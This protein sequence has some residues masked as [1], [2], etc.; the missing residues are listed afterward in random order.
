MSVLFRNTSKFNFSSKSI[1]EN[2]IKSNLKVTKLSIE[3]VSGGCGQAFKV[4]VA[5]SDFK[6][7]SLIKQHQLLNEILKEELKDIHS[8]TYKTSVAEDKI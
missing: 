7:K 4:E 1:L 2:L 6:N 3:D 8:I 5:S